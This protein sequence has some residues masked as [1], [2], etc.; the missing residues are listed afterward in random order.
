MLVLHLEVGLLGILNNLVNSVDFKLVRMH[1]RLVV[2]E[3][4]HHFFELFGALFKVLLVNNQL[5][6]DFWA[7]LL[8]EDVLQFDVQFLLLLDEYVLLR[9]FFGL[10]DQ[11]F[12]QTLDFLDEFVGLD[13]C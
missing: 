3:F 13:V 4:K 1:L 5:L 2:F 10:G 7:A 11:P 12:L 9:D 8:G 6:G